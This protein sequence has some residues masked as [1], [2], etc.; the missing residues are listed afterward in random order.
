MAKLEL[1]QLVREKKDFSGIVSKK[2]DIRDVNT[3]YRPISISNIIS[4]D[5]QGDMVVLEQNN[6]IKLARHESRYMFIDRKKRTFVY[7][8]STWALKKYS[9]LSHVFTRV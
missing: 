9:R 2:L 1:K 6:G 7:K 4:E 8:S 3:Y 5:E